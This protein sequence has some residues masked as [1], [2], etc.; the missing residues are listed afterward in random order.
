MIATE[1]GVDCLNAL[2]RGELAATE[3]YQ[4]AIAKMQAVGDIAELR[5]IHADH[6]EAANALRLSVRECGGKPEQGSAAWGAWAKLIEGAAAIFGESA[7]LKALKEG[8]ERGIHDY[9]E[10]IKETGLSPECRTLIRNQLL[11]QTE[12]HVQ[13]L[14]RMLAAR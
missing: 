13:A 14:D 12:E 3:T 9:R 6:R 4:Q 1:H 2:L 7:A 5:R 10:A 8:E 11:P